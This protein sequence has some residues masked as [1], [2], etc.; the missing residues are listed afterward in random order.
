VKQNLQYCSVVINTNVEFQSDIFVVVPLGFCKW[1]A[2]VLRLTTIF[3]VEV[4][5]ND[6]L[7]WLIK[8]IIIILWSLKKDCYKAT[9]VRTLGFN[10]SQA[11][12]QNFSLSKK[13]SCGLIAS[14]GSFQFNEL[15]LEWP[16]TCGFG[17]C[18]KLLPVFPI[19]FILRIALNRPYNISYNK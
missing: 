15:E 7:L 10:W 16:L 13:L 1:P 14:P 3:F 9:I 6:Q 5:H 17:R 11:Q 18:W 12:V 4:C 19:V 8:M 2:K